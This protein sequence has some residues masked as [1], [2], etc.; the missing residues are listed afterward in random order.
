MDGEGVGVGDSEGVADAEALVE[1]VGVGVAV[2]VEGGVV[3]VGDTCG[4][5]G[6]GFTTGANFHFNTLPLLAQ[7]TFLPRYVALAP[8]L[9]HFAPGLFAAIATDDGA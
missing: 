9:R 1:G 2:G 6:F 7:M 5:L 3:G 8:N 4:W